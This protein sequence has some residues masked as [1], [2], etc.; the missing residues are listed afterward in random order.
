MCGI[1][2]KAYF[3]KKHEVHPK[4]LKLMSNA[5]IHRGPD[6]EGIY[7][8]KNRRVGFASRRLAIIDLSQKG[9]QPMEY[10]GRYVITFNGE[11]YNFKE[12]KAKLIRQGYKFNSQTDT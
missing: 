4:E 11:I 2:G 8:S 3:N 5:I 9:H 1:A 6:D 12:E 7:I 10:G